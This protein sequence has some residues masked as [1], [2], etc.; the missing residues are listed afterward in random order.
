LADEL[1]CSMLCFTSRPILTFMQVMHV[2]KCIYKQ[3]FTNIKD[4]IHST[5]QLH[6]Y[7]YYSEASTWK[8]IPVVLLLFFN[9]KSCT[10]IINAQKRR[11]T[12]FLS[13]DSMQC[14][15]LLT[16]AFTSGISHWIANRQLSKATAD[17]PFS[18]VCR[19][20][21]MI[22]SITCCLPRGHLEVIAWY[23]L[24]SRTDRGMHHFYQ[25]IFRKVAFS[26]IIKNPRS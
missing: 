18:C 1:V 11:C 7:Y 19:Q 16:Y 20:L 3:V 9:H 15:L 2:T 12:N 4:G 13:D 22:C 14:L 25:W 8:P 10:V 6:K 24:C 5:W 17:R 21:L 26:S 23:P